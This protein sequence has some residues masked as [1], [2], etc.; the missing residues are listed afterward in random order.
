M[1]TLD[2]FG[3]RVEDSPEEREKFIYDKFKLA[4]GEQEMEL[5]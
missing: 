1:Y 3:F 2:V 4:I 5:H